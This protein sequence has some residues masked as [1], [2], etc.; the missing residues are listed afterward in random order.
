M[1]FIYYSGR[2][3]HR[4]QYF[5]DDISGSLAGKSRLGVHHDSM[6]NDRF[7]HL[8]DVF[9]HDEILAIEKGQTVE[10]NYRLMTID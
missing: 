6:G 9:R 5:F 1:Y 4:F 3:G 10:T 7:G 2:Y 8:L